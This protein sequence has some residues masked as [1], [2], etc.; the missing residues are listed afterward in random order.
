MPILTPFELDDVTDWE[1][2]IIPTDLVT[3]VNVAPLEAAVS[4]LT[5]NLDLL[6]RQLYTLG[7]FRPRTTASLP[8]ATLASRSV[9]RRDGS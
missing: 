3:P 2:V 1:D 7:V 6:K 4:P 8:P 9:R 5:D